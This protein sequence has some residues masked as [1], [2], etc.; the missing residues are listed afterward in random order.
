MVQFSLPRRSPEAEGVSRAALEKW[1][2]A[3]DRL[4]NVHSALVVRHGAV[5][6]E[7]FWA[8][9][10]ASTPQTMFS[11]SKTFTALAV[12]F[13]V[14]EGK[15]S[16]AD[17]V[18]DILRPSVGANETTAITPSVEERDL[19]RLETTATNEAARS[20]SASAALSDSSS[21]L[22]AS[23]PNT[24]TKAPA[25]ATPARPGQASG[26]AADLTRRNR[27]RT[28]GTP[29]V[30]STDPEAENHNKWLSQLTVKHLLTMS[31]GNRDFDA[32]GEA[33]G[34][35][36]E[37]AMAH[38]D[39]VQQ[40]LA[41][42]FRNA[43]GEKFLYNSASSF[44]LSAIVQKVTGHRV[45]DYLQPRLFEP[46]GITDAHWDQNPAGINLGGFG[47]YIKTEDIAKVGQLILD[48]G[49]WEGQQL[50]PAAWIAEMTSKQIGTKADS[51]WAGGAEFH[52]DD[53]S[54]DWAQGYGYQMWICT[55]DAV[56]GDGAFGQF[57]VIW[58]K[59][60]A[61]IAM[62][63]ATNN[64][65]DQLNTVWDYLSDA[66]T[67]RQSVDSAHPNGPQNDRSADG[68]QNDANPTPS[69]EEPHRG[70]SKPR[71]STTDGPLEKR[72]TLQ[73]LK[74]EP[75]TT[76][77]KRAD[78]V[79]FRVV[80][81]FGAQPIQ[82]AEISI[83]DIGN[84]TL[85]VCLPPTKAAGP[86][87]IDPPQQFQAGFGTWTRNGDFV[88]CY[89]WVNETTLEIK[90]IQLPG[91]IGWTWSLEFAG[92]GLTESQT[93]EKLK[94]HHD[95]SAPANH[96]ILITATQNVAFGPTELYTAAARRT[97]DV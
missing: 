73:T 1:L 27:Y 79:W 47:L 91:M 15:L 5:V 90:G 70:V 75:F 84:Q 61:V 16:L 6:A 67:P 45:M 43:P 8:P 65:G 76:T 96:G 42:K 59:F 17:H 81:E 9:Y 71:A 94:S 80:T 3:L 49:K 60:D 2:A 23:S 56:R 87:N 77:G 12:G 11:V 58:P 55:N 30:S 38:L 69:V 82:G 46:L 83:R 88:A 29:L 51:D 35:D 25:D 92:G 24:S 44:L 32:F 4:G 72:F 50:I 68:P 97:S 41:A 85:A 89:A 13:A 40:L 54:N 34:E 21:N 7:A 28:A 52:P 48:G 74:G 95:N 39:W 19:A 36:A 37:A 53:A 31:G 62:T 93:P 66:F 18:S 86:G 10:N 63:A 14:A 26:I 20:S 64:M 33:Y 78:G 22:V 57:M